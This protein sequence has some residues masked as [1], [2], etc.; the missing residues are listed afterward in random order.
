MP[1]LPILP[2]W[3]KRGDTIGLVCPAGPVRDVV[4][5]QAGIACIEQ[6]GFKV[7]ICGPAQPQ[8]SYLAASDSERAANLHRLWSDERIKAIIAMR[9]GFGCLRLVDLLDW[10]LFARTPKWL[11]GFSDITLLLHGLLSRSNVVS[12]HGPVISSLA[13]SDEAS[14]HA[15]FALLT[16]SFEERIKCKGV[17]ILRGGEGRGRLIGGNLTTLVHALATPWD[18]N[19]EGAIVLFE[20]TNEPLYRL[21]RL[22]TQLAL[23]GKLQRLSGLILGEFDVGGD[24]LAN[25]RLQEAVWLRV[26]EL[27]GPGFPVWG[28]FPIGH[29][30]RNLALPLGMEVMMDSG[31]GTLQLLPG[32]TAQA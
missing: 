17:E 5:L 4:R 32:S 6:M 16:G 15:L 21:D 29:R 1:E 22:L 12:V 27:V 31:S 2:P 26:M 25:L 13:A 18:Q 20:D 8:D 10:Q 7:Q 14:Q 9:G 23:S 11:V 19:W 3:L 24:T 28:N 30:Q